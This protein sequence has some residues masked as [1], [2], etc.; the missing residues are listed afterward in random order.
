MRSFFVPACPCT[1][2]CWCGDAR[3]QANF[4]AVSNLV[5]QERINQKK[6]GCFELE[7]EDLNKGRELI[8]KFGIDENQW[9][10][11][12]H[13]REA[14]SKAEGSNEFYRNFQVQEYFKAIEYITEK[15]GYVFRV[16]DSSMSNL[17]KMKNVILNQMILSEPPSV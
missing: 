9:F 15:G 10:V 8:K 17:P 7:Q 12:L 5:Y 14:S 2:L 3:T 1:S 16:G 11:C 13:V 6:L 4:P